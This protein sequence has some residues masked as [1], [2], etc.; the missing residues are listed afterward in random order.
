[1]HAALGRWATPRRLEGVLSAEVAGEGGGTWP[2]PGQV[3]VGQDPALHL[4][5]DPHGPT[6]STDPGNGKTPS[7]WS[8]P[9]LMTWTERG[10][11]V[12]PPGSTRAGKPRRLPHLT[13]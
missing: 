6:I 2:R 8:F 12:W 3:P 5:R 1:M 9:I 13:G 11:R 10:K 4:P 7:T